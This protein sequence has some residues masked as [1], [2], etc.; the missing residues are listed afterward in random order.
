MRN[1]DEI[2]EMIQR[3]TIILILNS[4]S[5]S[6]LNSLY[7]LI[8]NKYPYKKTE[9]KNTKGLI[10]K[11]STIKSKLIRINTD[12][13][14]VQFGSSS[15]SIKTLENFNTLRLYIM[16]NECK[17]LF[18]TSHFKLGTNGSYGN[19]SSINFDLILL[20]EKNQLKVITYGYGLYKWKDEDRIFNIDKLVR[21]TKLNKIKDI[22]KLQ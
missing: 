13:S 22:S 17:L 6:V 18:Q 3:S 9:L 2:H 11:I 19:F 20:I 21:N 4:H 15:T 5:K 16:E 14:R 12:L 8:Y 10:K 7:N 1:L